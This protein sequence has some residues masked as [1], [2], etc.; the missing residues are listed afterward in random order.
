MVEKGVQTQNV[1]KGGCEQGVDVDEGAEVNNEKMHS[2][3][4]MLTGC[5]A[6]T[7]SKAESII[8]PTDNDGAYFIPTFSSG[9]SQALF[10]L[11]YVIRGPAESSWF[12]HSATC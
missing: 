7:D 2:L 9:Y 11:M 5:I 10:S 4:R 8:V 3:T 1:D 12:L 6:I